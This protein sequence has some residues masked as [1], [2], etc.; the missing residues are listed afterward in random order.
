MY[1]IHCPGICIIMRYQ[2][3]NFGVLQRSPPYSH[4][5]RSLTISHL[6][7]SALSLPPLPP[8]LVTAPRM[9]G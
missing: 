6:T 1:I 9:S 8:Y 5:R 4:P 2:L 7:F 3:A